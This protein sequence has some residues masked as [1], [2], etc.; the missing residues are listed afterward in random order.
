[1]SIR[2]RC[3]RPDNFT[4]P[5]RTPWGGRTILDRYKRD[6][7]L[8]A[9]TSLSRAGESWE[10]SVEPSFPSRL[11]DDDTLLGEAIAADPVAWLGSAGAARHGGQTP[12]LI[13]LL[14][15]ADT[16]S[17]QVHPEAGD[18][19][20]G[21]GESGKPEAWYILQSRDG[22]GLYLDF[23]DGV[24]RV[25]VE[26]CLRHGGPLDQLMN[27]VPVSAGDA[28]L[29]RAGTVHAVGAGVTL[30][31]PQFV[32]PGRRAV[33][34]RYWDWNRRY[35][36]RGELSSAGTPRPLHVERSLAV[37]AWEGPRGA[38][39]VDACM[40]R[41]ALM[42]AGSLARTEVARCPQ[43]ALERWAGAGALE[44]PAQGTLLGVVCVAGA[45]RVH[46]ER[47]DAAIRCGQSM[48]IPAACGAVQISSQPADGE[49][50]LLVT[51]TAA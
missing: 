19:A 36:S 8:G 45:A 42:T 13:K 32:L 5:A 34:Y 7:D 11:A 20:L 48:V 41:P 40:Q 15:A 1:V 12:L 17:V 25:D 3:L 23:Q 31:E 10:I 4:P 38:A 22:A 49:V 35:D 14:D 2:P 51:R 9:A 29:I 27:F 50:E 18:P 39:A 47:G 46:T 33:T 28:L 44:V 26:A 37:T 43:F 6:L 30:L 24:E 16:L 21:P